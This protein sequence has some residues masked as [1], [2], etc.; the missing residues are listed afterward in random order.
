MNIFS[1]RQSSKKGPTPPLESASEE[2]GQAVIG[3]V[4]SAPTKKHI[5]S[6]QYSTTRGNGIDSRESTERALNDAKAEFN[7][8]RKNGGGKVTSTTA[9]VLSGTADQHT[10]S[11]SN[12]TKHETVG[13]ALKQVQKY[14]RLDT[15]QALND[16]KAEFNARRAD[17][18]GL[19]VPS[20]TVTLFKAN[21]N[22]ATT[23]SSNNTKHKTN[24]EALLSVQEWGRYDTKQALVDAKCG[25]EKRIAEQNGSIY[26]VPEEIVF[27]MDS[28][29]AR[30]EVL[31]SEK[32][33]TLVTKV[34]MKEFW[35]DRRSVTR[36]HL[37]EQDEEW[38]RRRGDSEREIRSK[39]LTRLQSTW[40]PSF[41]DEGE[42]KDA[43]RVLALK[44][45]ITPN[46]G[47]L[48]LQSEGRGKSWAPKRDLS[49][50]DSRRADTSNALARERSAWRKRMGLPEV[51]DDEI[52][53]SS[54]AIR[55]SAVL[56]L[57]LEAAKPTQMTTN[58]YMP[59]SVQITKPS[60]SRAVTVSLERSSDSTALSLSKVSRV[61]ERLQMQQKRGIMPTTKPVN[62]KRYMQPSESSAKSTYE[63]KQA[64][65]KSLS[66]ERKEYHSNYREKVAAA[67][68]LE[69]ERYLQRTRNPL[70]KPGEESRTRT[71]NA[72][73]DQHEKKKDQRDSPVSPR[74][75]RVRRATHRTGVSPRSGQVKSS[76]YGQRSP[77][78]PRSSPITNLNN[79]RQDSPVNAN[80]RQFRQR[81]KTYPRPGQNMSKS[82]QKKD[83]NEKIKRRTITTTNRKPDISPVNSSRP[84]EVRSSGYGKVDSIREATKNRGRMLLARFRLRGGGDSQESESGAQMFSIPKSNSGM[85]VTSTIN[86]SETMKREK[87]PKENIPES[88]RTSLAEGTTQRMLVPDVLE[89]ETIKSK[90]RT[91]GT[92]VAGPKV[93]PKVDSTSSEAPASKGKVLT[94]ASSPPLPNP[95]VL[96]MKEPKR[97]QGTSI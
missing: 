93:I 69:R 26:T 19:P 95:P 44:M 4:T 75:S 45:D 81:H 46:E 50:S 11:S 60:K 90:D 49:W 73:T 72:P 18:E 54:K 59:P 22:K 88:P 7:A 33:P 83:A 80:G 94:D 96:S 91:Q 87:G 21:V 15:K 68:R 61:A 89:S 97:N 5:S 56:S 12:D 67:N 8:R 10:A 55:E 42:R 85:S 17:G 58:D 28:R 76:G 62:S 40:K 74:N 38:C 43:P 23:S 2:N 9:I 64:A 32:P 37:S 47:G 66:D 14:G 39:S 92:L 84:P 24:G 86:P 16:A 63:A 77:A 20:T 31:P 36:Q 71:P 57:R 3:E 79:I 41:Q 65:E 27:R 6:F 13:E 78:S 52:E 51:L 30:K 34:E 53:Q 82:G 35:V 25:Y 70:Q 29:G 1:R 48:I